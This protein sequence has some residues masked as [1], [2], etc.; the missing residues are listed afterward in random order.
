M[1]EQSNKNVAFMPIGMGVASFQSVAGSPARERR[2]AA[3]PFF[4]AVRRAAP[5]T[6]SGARAWR[7]SSCRACSAAAS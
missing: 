7:R 2:C 5:R 3:P 1:G 4:A 6:G